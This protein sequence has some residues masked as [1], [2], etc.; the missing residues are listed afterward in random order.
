LRNTLEV[1]SDELWQKLRNKF[2]EPNILVEVVKATEELGEL[3]DLALRISKQQRDRKMATPKDDWKVKVGDEI[4]DI[5]ISCYFGKR[6]EHRCMENA[7]EKD[8]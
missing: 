7:R 1:L 3:A 2:P 6:F 5:I 8:D 4:S